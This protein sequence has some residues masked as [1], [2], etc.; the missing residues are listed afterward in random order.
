MDSLDLGFPQPLTSLG[1]PK[2]L[3]HIDAVLVWGNNNRTFF[4]SGN[5]YWRFDDETQMT[6]PDYPRDM[7][8][9]RGVG[10]HINAAFQHYDGTLNELIKLFLNS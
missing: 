6:E 5:E 2:W 4:F 3:S 9:W 10:Y 8:L 7:R 1:L